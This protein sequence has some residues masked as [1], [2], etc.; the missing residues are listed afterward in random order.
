MSGF[1]ILCALALPAF[2]E[3][4]AEPAAKAVAPGAVRDPKVQAMLAEISI[5]RI[6]A[7]I[8][9]LA[10]FDTRH[11]LSDT[12]SPTRGIGAARRWIK[13]E[14][15]RVSAE[16]GGRLKVSLD[17]YVQQPARRV[18]RPTEI[19][20]VVATLPG[21]QKESAGR[22]IVI[23]GHYDSIPSMRG[24]V[25]DPD[26]SA[27][28][29][30]DDA[31]GTAVV[32][33]LAEVMS[34]YEF[35]AT[36]VFIAFA[37]EEQGL[38]GSTHFAKAA[39][40]GS[41]AI[42]AMITNDIVGNT[43]GGRGRRDNRTIRLFSEGMPA[44]DSAL[45][46]RLR[47]VGGENDSPS[48]QLARFIDETGALYMPYFKVRLVFRSDRFLRGG[49]HL[50]FLQEGYPAVRFT[51]PAENYARQHQ[52]VRREDGVNYGDVLGGVDFAYVSEVARLNG[53]A[54]AELALA[55]TPVEGASIEVRGF[56]YDTTLSWTAS[57][58][59]DLAGY[60]VVWRDTTAPRWEHSLYVG[61]VSRVTLPELSRDDWQFG[62]RA[63]DLEGHRSPVSLPF[64]PAPPAGAA[65]PASP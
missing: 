58:A 4:P 2:F 54:V 63:V 55:P 1:T 11:T 28:G 8:E 59:P 3:G 47:R 32:M 5:P 29:A 20:N 45:A 39:R 10:G 42:E 23:G 64:P 44:L 46:A 52:N 25:T 62:V 60:E 57:S 7:R 34:K 31:S 24:Q 65:A 50:P 13:A 48:R 53:A 35:D 26:A 18:P 40:G 9:K 33:E 22:W 12:N 41:R 14:F 36:I 37:G 49:D 38:L 56:A 51:E 6:Q 61:N 17:S 43:E 15:D 19:V 27:P 16:R 30:N 21:Q